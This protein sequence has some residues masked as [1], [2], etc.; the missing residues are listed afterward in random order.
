VDYGS[1]R[2]DTYRAVEA[3][4]G[5]SGLGGPTVPDHRFLQDSLGGTGD[6]DSWSY[7]IGAN[8]Y[9]VAI[10]L[11][12][13]DWK[14]A[15]DPDFDMYLY[16]PDGALVTSSTGV[17]RQE[18][19]AVS[20][21]KTGTYTVKV[22]SYLGSG[23]Y[24]FDL[25]AGLG[26]PISP[27][28]PKKMHISGIAMSTLTKSTSTQAEATVTVVDS[29]GNPVKGVTVSG[30][31]SG[32]TKGT[33]SGTTDTNGQVVFN[34]RWVKKAKGTFTFTVTNLVKTDWTYDPSGNEVTSAS[35]TV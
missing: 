32:L 20:I 23:V 27:P 25:S 26:E 7:N 35:I 34:S 9:P 33:V 16:A 12:M 5:A 14:A 11:I 10:T 31:W 13:P 21:T 28:D 17:S 19:I 8:T 3:A 29:S 2:L 1:G 24:F 4:K 30:S 6:S 22:K 18:T 15:G